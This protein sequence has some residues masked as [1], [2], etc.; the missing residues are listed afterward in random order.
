VLAAVALRWRWWRLR[1]APARLDAA[2]RYLVRII[3][4]EARA[5]PQQEL[6]APRYRLEGES[7][8]R[9]QPA[10]RRLAGATAG[11]TAAGRAP[12]RMRVVEDGSNTATLTEPIPANVARIR[13]EL[14]EAAWSRSRRTRANRVLAL[15]VAL[16][17]VGCLALVSPRLA[18]R[19]P[20]P[21]LP[22]PA[23]TALPAGVVVLPTYAHL[24]ELSQRATLFHSTVDLDDPAAPSLKTSPLPRA[25][26]LIRHS[27]GP[28][29]AVAED[30]SLRVLDD[31]RLATA[32]LLSTSLSP[33][34]QRAA[35]GDADG[36]LIVDLTSGAVRALPGTGPPAALAWR[37][38]RNVIAPNFSGGLQINVDTGGAKAFASVAG[39][40]VVTNQVGAPAT[41]VELIPTDRAVPRVRIWRKQPVAV[42]NPVPGT[43]GADEVEDR[44]LFGPVWIGDWL[45]PGYY[46][47]NQL[48]RACVAAAIPLPGVL[49]FAHA[50]VGAVTISGLY[51]STLVTVDPTTLDLLGF[52]DPETVLLNA[53]GTGAST[54]VA[55]NPRSGGLL[56][57]TTVSDTA[58]ISLAAL[59]SSD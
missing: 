40:D 31:P 21:D 47:G 3:G 54:I 6:H 35:L 53:T 24:S 50:A 29:Y 22:E 15:T 33:D 45:G 39:Q 7:R 34:G 30:A 5:W 10:R 55:W 41:L 13:A 57:V 16:V 56:R 2:Q 32:H 8:R 11:G 28:L 1:S 26:A 37:D 46:G 19:F 36:L 49:G 58:Q 51:E 23:P 42:T 48:V 9:E 59:G 44:P 43:P 38:A 4:R 52:V 17:T 25:I 27:T 18:T 12:G 20:T 14:A